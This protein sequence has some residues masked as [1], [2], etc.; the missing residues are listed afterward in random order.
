V[1][2]PF[3]PGSTQSLTLSQVFA[4]ATSDSTNCA[5]TTIKTFN[6]DGTTEE[7]SA[8]YATATF[9]VDGSSQVTTTKKIRAYDSSG[10][11]YVEGTLNIH[12]CG[13]EDITPLG[14]IMFVT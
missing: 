14:I 10:S 2:Y 7:A 4:F 13:G 1:D 8:P 9:T 3:P 11:N 12:I 6:I 5:L